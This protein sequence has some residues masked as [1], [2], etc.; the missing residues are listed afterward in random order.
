L[1]A[2]AVT[3]S[4]V[5]LTA[6]P[7]RAQDQSKTNPIFRF[8]DLILPEDMK[9]LRNLGTPDQY[10][11]PEILPNGDI[12]IRRKPQPLPPPRDGEIDL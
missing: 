10:E 6:T 12:L 7:I 9:K 1:K 3:L 8:L 2:I 11:T 4:L 5:L